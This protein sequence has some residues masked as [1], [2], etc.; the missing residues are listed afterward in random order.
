MTWLYY[1]YFQRFAFLGPPKAVE[2]NRLPWAQDTCRATERI[3]PDKWIKMTRWQTSNYDVCTTLTT[4]RW[5]SAWI[6]L[7][8]QWWTLAAWSPRQG[9]TSCF[10]GSTD[11]WV[12]CSVL[13]GRGAGCTTRTVSICEEQD[14]LECIELE[15]TSLRGNTSEFRYWH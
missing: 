10:Q 1:T 4:L 8:G 6:V 13:S 15:A 5:H 9:T 12:G 7:W 11:W 2:M 3:K 14:R